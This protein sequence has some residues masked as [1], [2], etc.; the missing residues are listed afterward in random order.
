MDASAAVLHSVGMNRWR[1]IVVVIGVAIW[2]LSGPLAMASNDC[3][4]MGAMCE[5]PCGAN[6][7]A[8]TQFESNTAFDQ[9]LAVVLP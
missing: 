5:G 2:G 1:L 4:T 3:M 7:C 6:Q 8:T 9:V